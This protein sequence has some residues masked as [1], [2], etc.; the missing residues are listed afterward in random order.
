MSTTLSL[1]F[2]VSLTV[3][4]CAQEQQNKDSAT[5]A[6]IDVDPDV[7]G[8]G[9]LNIMVIGTTSSISGAEP[10]SPELIAEE[11]Q[12]ILSADE[13]INIEVKVV[14]E[15]VYMSTPITLGLGG[16]G[17]EY[18]YTHHSHSLAQYYYWP[19]GREEREANLMGEGSFDWDYVIIAADPYIVSTMPGYYALGANKVAEK[20][21]EGGA[22]PLLLM[23]WPKSEGE[24][25][26]IE[27]FAD[28]THRIADGA[29]VSLS[30]VPAGL[31]WGELADSQT[32]SADVHPT[33]NGAYV[34]AAAAYSH[35]LRRSAASSAYLYDVDLAVA[36][37][38]AVLGEA[39]REPYE[40]SREA[41]D[42]FSSCDVS[43]EVLT[44]H[45]TGSSSENG[46]LAGLNW[47]FEQ[48]PQTLQVGEGN[49][50]T[51]NY[52]RANSNFEPDKRYTV[53]SDRF[54][55]SFGF[56]MQDHG[57]YGDSSMLYGIDRRDSGVMND[58][59]LG[60]AMFMVEQG[61]IPDVR[62]IP[63]RTLF[64]Q[65]REINPDQSAYRDSWHMHRDLDKAIGAYMYTLLTGE[66][67]LGEEPEDPTSESWYAW[68]GHRIGCQTAWTVMTLKGDAPF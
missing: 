15:D 62:A 7:N 19:D 52:G 10:F 1:F 51:F 55:V 32:D 40:G 50:S 11:L 68:N 59:D 34:A 43:G 66:C 53:D 30:A 29:K 20:V 47:V 6:L 64:A 21:S 26:S 23:V 65:M 45:H 13:S 56:P 60:T 24:N 35:I 18:T 36:A 41:V 37:H 58:T 4:G 31:A 28:I 9:L 22:Q 63:V 39:E 8:D 16:N 44:Y 42:P 54:E 49:S 25:S 67:A 27:D 3:M 38:E 33:P 57:N 61:E 5:L 2:T 48:A 14:A 17:A 12:G 46:I